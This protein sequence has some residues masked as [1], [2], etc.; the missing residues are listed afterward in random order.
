M[1]AESAKPSQ[2]KRSRRENCRSGL[3]PE[4]EVGG[5]ML[6]KSGRRQARRHAQQIAVVAALFVSSALASQVAAASSLRTFHTTFQESGQFLDEGATEACGFPVT[7]GIDVR[8]VQNFLFDASGN[9]VHAVF[10]P[11]GTATESANGIT[12]SGQI[13][14]N[15]I[16]FDKTQQVYEVGLVDVLKLPGGGVV[17]IDVGRIVWSLDAFNNGGAPT[18]VEGPHP[19]L[20]GDFAALCAALTP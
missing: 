9:F 8:I 5:A 11:N 10:T 15:L 3:C 1:G 12:L 19:A 6:A 13:E 16:F 20:E 7:L 17:L 4:G 2:S 14:D 18:V